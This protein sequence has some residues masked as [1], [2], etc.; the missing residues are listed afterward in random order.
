M[1]GGEKRVKKEEALGKGK[2]SSQT[3]ARIVFQ[4][5][6]MQPSPVLLPLMM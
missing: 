1:V 3:A 2:F 6:N 5:H 4:K